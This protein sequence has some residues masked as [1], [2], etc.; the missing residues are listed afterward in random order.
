MDKYQFNPFTIPLL[1]GLILIPIFL[2][3]RFGINSYFSVN[4]TYFETLIPILII[5]PILVYF[6]SNK[7]VR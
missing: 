7:R 2:I 5:V 3:L 4:I 6:G 1:I